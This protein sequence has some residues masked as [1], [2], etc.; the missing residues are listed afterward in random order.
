LLL[1]VGAQRGVVFRVMAKAGAGT[2][3]Q[4]AEKPSLLEARRTQVWRYLAALA[5]VFGLTLY[6]NRQD[7]YAAQQSAQKAT[8]PAGNQ[9]VAPKFRIARV[10]VECVVRCCVVRCFVHPNLL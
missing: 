5:L 4:G 9:I 8:L 7:E 2:S 10:P 1:P 3:A 6:V